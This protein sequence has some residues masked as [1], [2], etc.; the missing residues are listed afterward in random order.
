MI[1]FFWYGDIVSSYVIFI[2]FSLDVPILMGFL[3]LQPHLVTSTTKHIRLVSEP[4][5]VG[6]FLSHEISTFCILT[7]IGLPFFI[8][9]IGEI[10]DFVGNPDPIS[11][12]DGALLCRDIPSLRL[13]GF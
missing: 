5:R 7:K 13:G 12:G 2:G 3:T 8:P 9:E 6:N 1:D 10:G 11:I 4:I